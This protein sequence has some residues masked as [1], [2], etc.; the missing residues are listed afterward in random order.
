MWLEKFQDLGDRILPLSLYGEKD[1]TIRYFCTPNESIIF[2]R[3]GIDGIHFCVYDQSGISRD[4]SPVF[5]V[6]PGSDTPTLPI[7]HNFKEFIGLLITLKDAGAIEA[8]ANRSFQDFQT[9]MQ[10]EPYVHDQ[11]EMRKIHDALALLT[12]FPYEQIDKPYLY[13]QQT[14]DQL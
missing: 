14:I 10:A 2:A 8:A 3:L 12:S 9:Y 4:Q 6:S 5:V 1:Q 11:T 7:A 13:I